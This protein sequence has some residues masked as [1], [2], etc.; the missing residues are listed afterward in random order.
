MTIGIGK[1]LAIRIIHP[2]E[3]GV[4]LVMLDIIGVGVII[5]HSIAVVAKNKSIGMYD[6]FS[7]KPIQK[8]RGQ[9]Q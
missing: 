7:V 8:S 9:C 6:Y 5:F 3:V 2:L 1:I 4:A